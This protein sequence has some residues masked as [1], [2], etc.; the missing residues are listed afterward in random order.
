[1]KRLILLAIL[2]FGVPAVLAGAGPASAA[3]DMCA[4]YDP[5][6]PP[7]PPLPPPPPPPPPPPAPPP[8]ACSDGWDND[9]DGARDWQQ[10]YGCLQ[11]PS[12]NNEGDNEL[13]ANVA[14]GEAS[15]ACGTAGVDAGQWYGSVSAVDSFCLTSTSRCKT[16]KVTDAISEAGW[17]DVNHYLAEYT[18]CYRP[19]NGIVTVKS[20][21]GKSTFS[22]WPW[23]YGGNA[24]GFPQ[25]VRYAK[26][27]DFKYVWKLEF[28]GLGWV[29]T[30]WPFL[31][32][33]FFDN[34]TQMVTEAG[35]G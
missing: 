14:W 2:I 18:V 10:D 8:P 5:P 31:T 27:V 17:V 30:K 3:D 29:S 33:R 20:R 19:N 21:S 1:M 25:H 13:Y 15:Y 26:F 9:G 7:P 11:D 28:A 12:D 34:N 24:E 22:R 4:C 16:Q 6:P 32:I 23:N 35:I